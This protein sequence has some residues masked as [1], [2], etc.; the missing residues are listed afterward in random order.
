MG[1]LRLR[2][3]WLFPAVLALAGCASVS[4]PG[5]G[6]VPAPG[7]NEKVAEVSA[8]Q[9]GEETTGAGTKELAAPAGA[10]APLAAARGDVATPV[11]EPVVPPGS[12]PSAEAGGLL[13]ESMPTGA[14]V[15]IDG[16]P[17]GRTPYR[18]AVEETAR[19]FFR[20]EVT[21]RVRFVATTAGESSATVAETFGPTDRVPR[22]VIFTPDGARRIW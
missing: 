4:P 21:V 1:R 20:G 22:R 15:V 17:V 6:V 11:D 8:S 5:A 14:T 7:S 10:A 19:G 18:L 16:L 12:E 13:I 9:P 2:R 3:W